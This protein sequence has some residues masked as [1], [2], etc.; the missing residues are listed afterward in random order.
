M[1]HYIKTYTGTKRDK[2]RAAL[3]DMRDFTGNKRFDKI[4]EA[5]VASYLNDRV[6]ARQHIK[7]VVQA[8]ALFVGVQG[9]PAYA[10]ARYTLETAR[11]IQMGSFGLIGLTNR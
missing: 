4:A 6:S 2:Y 9:L 11:R 10:F 3:K 5:C 7:T 1:T 8:L